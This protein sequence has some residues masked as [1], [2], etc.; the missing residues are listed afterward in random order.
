M[1]V[2]GKE[3]EGKNGWMDDCVE[4]GDVYVVKEDVDIYPYRRKSLFSIHMF[5]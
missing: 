5:T 2:Y 1:K 4:D 3:G